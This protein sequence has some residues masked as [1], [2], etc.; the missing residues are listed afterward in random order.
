MTKAEDIEL[1]LIRISEAMRVSVYPSQTRA[2][3]HVRRAF[4]CNRTIE[5]PQWLV[6]L[7]LLD[8]HWKETSAINMSAEAFVKELEGVLALVK[9]DA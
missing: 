4:V 8:G 9:E 3:V 1:T 6:A 5:F 2:I 7:W